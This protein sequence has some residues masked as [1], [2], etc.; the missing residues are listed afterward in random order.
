MSKKANKI[1]DKLYQPTNAE[2]LFLISKF[3]PSLHQSL[4]DDGVLQEVLD[5][6]QAMH[7]RSEASIGQIDKYPVN[8]KLGT[9]RRNAKGM[10]IEIV[11][12][13]KSYHV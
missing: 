9:V 4:M 12:D 3:S 13:N 7:N 5:Q 1:A 8:G 6:L 10:F 2:D 11:Y